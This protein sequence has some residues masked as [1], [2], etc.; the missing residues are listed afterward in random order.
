MVC[1][2]Y[3]KKIRSEMQPQIMNG[4][5]RLKRIS[6][7]PETSNPH[8]PQITSSDPFYKWLFCYYPFYRIEE[9]DQ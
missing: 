4:K 5:L 3:D 6:L 1:A 2:Y 9:F 7:Y 8:Q